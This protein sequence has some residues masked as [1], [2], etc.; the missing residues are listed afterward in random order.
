MCE[1]VTVVTGPVY[2]SAC[3]FAADIKDADIKDAD[4]KDG[5]LWSFERDYGIIFMRYF[6]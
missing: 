1:G 6:L 3:L 2:L 5:K 4:I